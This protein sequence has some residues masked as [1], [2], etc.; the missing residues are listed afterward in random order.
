[1]RCF[2][3]ERQR[4][5]RPAGE[6]FNGAMHPPAEHGGRVDAVLQAIGPAETP[7]DQGMEPLLRVHSADYLE[8]LRTAHRQWRDAGREGDAYPYTFRWS[9]GAH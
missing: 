4:A 5:H 9:D 1:M 8:F 6:F 3:D 2:W 7:A